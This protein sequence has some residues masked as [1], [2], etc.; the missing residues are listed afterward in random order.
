MKTVYFLLFLSLL[1]I[2]VISCK[3]DEEGPAPPISCTIASKKYIYPD[4]TF[5]ETKYTYTSTGRL[6]KM[7]EHNS[8]GKLLLRQ[9]YEFSN[10]KAV[11]LITSTSTGKSAETVFSYDSDKLKKIEHLEKKADQNFSKLYEK[12]FEYTGDK[13]SRVNYTFFNGSSAFYALYEYTGDN[14]TTVKA[15]ETASEQLLEENYY[16]Y[17]DKA[18]P[19]Y[20][21]HPFR[22]GQVQ[23][24]SKNNVIHSKIVAHRHQPQLPEVSYTYEYNSTGNPFK[25]VVNAP[26][27]GSIAEEEYLYTCH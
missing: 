22:A 17:D 1:G 4:K 24:A 16:H 10:G 3:P 14:I 5:N 12:T 23:E 15:Y 18:N 6:Q 11:K 27:W 25:K 9:E 19:F 13:I 20:Q 2:T 8:T 26:G 7:E 21:M